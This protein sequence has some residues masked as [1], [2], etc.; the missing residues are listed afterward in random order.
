MVMAVMLFVEDHVKIA[1]VDAGFYHSADCNLKPVSRD[2][3]E[4]LKQL[5]PV[6]AQIQKGCNRHISADSC[7]AFKVQDLISLHYLFLP[8]HARRLICVAM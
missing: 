2:L 1:A 7:P 3:I 8:S 5:F 6:S 4:H